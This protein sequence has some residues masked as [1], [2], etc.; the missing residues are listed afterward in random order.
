MTQFQI[1]RKDLTFI[2][3]AISLASNSPC[4]CQHG[5]VLVQN[6]KII[7]RGFNNFEPS[8]YSQSCK[9]THAEVGALTQYFK[10]NKHSCFQ[11]G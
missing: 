1:S 2:Q 11:G 5:C 9:S 10:W 6:G 7:G 8:P 3:E 4:Y